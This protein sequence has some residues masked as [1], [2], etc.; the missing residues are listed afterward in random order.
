MSTLHWGW[1]RPPLSQEGLT[2]G[3]G[4][5]IENQTRY[6][7]QVSLQGQTYNLFSISIHFLLNA[8][9]KQRHSQEKKKQIHD[10]LAQYQEKIQWYED[11]TWWDNCFSCEEVCRQA[12]RLSTDNTLGYVLLSLCGVEII[13]ALPW[14]ALL[15]AMHPACVQ[16]CVF[17][18]ITCITVATWTENCGSINVLHAIPP[19]YTGREECGDSRLYHS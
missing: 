11:E 10:V 14:Q 4:L 5:T 18:Q 12:V 2:G 3:W 7:D 6:Q 15:S 9:A 17:W 8:I 19:S 13:M 1:A 16:H